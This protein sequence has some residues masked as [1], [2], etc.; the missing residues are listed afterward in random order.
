MKKICTILFV[1]AFV[2]GMV[3]VACRN[4]DTNNNQTAGTSSMLIKSGTFNMGSPENEEGRNISEIQHTVTLTKDFYI[5]AYEVT[6]AQ[7]EAVMRNN[8]SDFTGPNRPVEQVSWYDTIVFCNTLSMMENRT[9]A[10]TINGNTDP[11]DWG[12][13]PAKKNAVWDAVICNW[14]ADGYRLP[15]EA[16]WEYACRAGTTTAYY[17]GDTITTDQANYSNY[18]GETTD[19]GSFEANAQGLYDMAGNLYEW[20]WDWYDD[21]DAA[22]VTDPT[23]APSGAYRVFRGGSWA[24]PAGHRHLR[25]AFRGG[26]TVPSRR[27]IY[28]GFRVVR[29]AE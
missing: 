16:E 15:T 13:V 9:P 1:A 28:I 14:E 17:T 24:C 12:T 2:W 18:Y 22:A 21:Y 25:S 27:G 6:Q 5:G 8:P 3:F 23:G 7:Y 11:A 20:C 29:S 10:Y 4:K 26:D 19:A